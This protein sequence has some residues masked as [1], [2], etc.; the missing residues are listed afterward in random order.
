VKKID[1]GSAKRAPTSKKY[2][3]ITP[4]KINTVMQ[5]METTHT[6]MHKR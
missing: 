6:T 3:E 5:T 4:K 1:M 2:R